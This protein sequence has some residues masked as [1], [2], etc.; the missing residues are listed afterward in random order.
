MRA[1]WEYRK[2][3]RIYCVLAL[4]FQCYGGDLFCFK[5]FPKPFKNVNVGINWFSSVS[6]GKYLRDSKALYQRSLFQVI[7]VDAVT[8]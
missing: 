5:L 8:G 4:H 2:V 6:L 3:G 7:T 1:L